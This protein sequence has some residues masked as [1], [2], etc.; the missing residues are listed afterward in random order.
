MN[1]LNFK[2][3]TGAYTGIAA[4][5]VEGKTLHTTF[6]LPINLDEQ[7]TSRMN[8][9]SIEAQEIRTTKLFIIDEASMISTD[10]L[11]TIH[12]L[13]VAVTGNVNV[14]FGG[15]CVVL[16]G[17]F[18]QTLP[19]TPDKSTITSIQKCL[20]NYIYW[21]QFVRIALTQNMRALEGE[22]EFKEWTL[23]VGD[24][25][26]PTIGNGLI[27]IPNRVMCPPGQN[28]VDAVYGVGPLDPATTGQLNRAI[29][30]PTNEEVFRVNEQV[31]RKLEG[32][33]VTYTSQD[34]APERDNNDPFEDV[35]VETLNA[36][37]PTGLPP[38][39]LNLKVGAI[40]MLIKN[41]NVSEGLCNG[42]RLRVTHCGPLVIRATILFG[43]RRNEEFLFS[44]IAFQFQSQL[45]HEQNMRRVQYPFRLAFAMTIN[46]SQ[47]QTFDR[48]GLLLNKP[49]FAHGQLYVAISRV[50][51]FDSLKIIIED[52]P[53]GQNMQGRFDNYPN[54][55]F[56]KNVVQ[57]EVLRN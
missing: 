32:E 17:D 22:N 10:A 27:Q 36:Q 7:S 50:R 1:G 41:L 23:R 14:P 38:Y 44:K 30:C 40:V 13:L 25:V 33:E 5:L 57:P 35:M 54:T 42:T 2:V 55:V 45:N 37:Q 43:P 19:I 47:G 4:S 12:N 9:N 31:L 51:S 20:K 3:I 39:R 56:T 28:I 34:S 53:R 24:G 15:K 46:K 52:I 26:E 49:V 8:M 48:I 29:L 18:R 21:N 16:A 6:G 11:N